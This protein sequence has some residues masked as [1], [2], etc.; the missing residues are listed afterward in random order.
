MTAI[1]NSGL[2]KITQNMA[3]NKPTHITQFVL[4]KVIG[5]D[6]KAPVN[7]DEVLPPGAAISWQGP[8][9]RAAAISEHKV[10]YSLILDSTVGP[11]EFNWIGL[12]DADGVLIAVSYVPLQSKTKYEGEAIGNTLTRNFVLA[13]ASA[14]T[15]L[16]V[17]IDPQTWQF[18]FTDLI[19]QKV[20]A[21]VN[22]AIADIE[23]SLGQKVIDGKVY[24]VVTADMQAQENSNYLFMDKAVV[25]LPARAGVAACNCR[26]AVDHSVDL[27]VGDCLIKP[28]EVGEKISTK[29]GAFDQ[30]RILAAGPEFGFNLINNGWRV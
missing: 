18:D 19:D 12:V 25:T 20:D 15:A 11:F 24:R 9:T 3:A 21:A 27:T 14:K 13:F 22:T 6:N 7:P 5:L 17:T 28:A 23:I 10:V 16:D 1:I 29:D 2:T 8:V 26:F 4:A 30:V